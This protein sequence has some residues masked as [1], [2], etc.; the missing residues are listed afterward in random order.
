M[1]SWVERLVVWPVRPWMT[2]TAAEDAI[3]CTVLPLTRTLSG[4]AP[5]TPDSF[6]MR[7][8]MPTAEPELVTPVVPMVLPTNSPS[9]VPLLLALR[10]RFRACERFPIATLFDTS[11]ARLPPLACETPMA[12]LLL[13]KVALAALQVIRPP[14]PEWSQFTPVPVLGAAPVKVPPVTFSFIVAVEPAGAMKLRRSAVTPVVPSSEMALPDMSR[15]VSVPALFETST[16]NSKLLRMV[17]LVM[18]VGFGPAELVP[19]SPVNSTPESSATASLPL[20]STSALLSTKPLTAA[21][22]MPESALVVTRSELSAT[23]SAVSR[24]TPWAVE[25][26]MV[27]PVQ[28]GSAVVQLPP[29]PATRKPPGL[30][31]AEVFRSTM[32]EGAPFAETLV[33]WTLSG[34]RAAPDVPAISTAAAAPVV[35]TTPLVEV[36]VPELFTAWRARTPAA[37]AMSRSEKETAAALSVSRTPVLPELLTAV[38]PKEA[39]PET[40]STRRP[41]PVLLVEKVV[42]KLMLAAMFSRSTAAAPVELTALAEFVRLTVPLSAT[43]PR[44]PAALVLSWTGPA[45]VIVP[46]LLSRLTASVVPFVPVTLEAAS[47]R[48]VPPARLWMSTTRPPPLW[49]TAVLLKLMAVAPPLTAT[50]TPVLLPATVLFAIVNVPA[51]LRRV[52]PPAPP[53]ALAPTFETEVAPAEALPKMAEEEAALAAAFRWST[54]LPLARVTTLPAELPSTGRLV[55]AGRA[56]LCAGALTPKRVSAASS[57]VPWPMSRWPSSSRMPPS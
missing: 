6:W 4:V 39:T 33:N 22:L 45:N 17:L 19:V 37:G 47:K 5:A 12:T 7:M 55:A 13:V 38:L 48:T 46:E 10:A 56:S 36:T 24:L 15:L 25:F 57:P 44:A 42:A 40:L 21:P 52:T 29:A 20:A 26:W 54:E 14:V 34:E 43:R 1:V 27:P 35:T 50:A 30:P 11:K 2:L 41:R 3:S 9:L 32:P 18:L 31:A 53:E 49:L 51:W 16:W 23:L 28:V 8:P